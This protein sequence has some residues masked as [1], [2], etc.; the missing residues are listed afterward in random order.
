MGFF[1][2]ADLIQ[3][4]SASASSSFFD[5][6]D[7]ME[8]PKTAGFWERTG[9][10]LLNIPKEGSTRLGE[11]LIGMAGMALGDNAEVTRGVQRQFRDYMG[12]AELQVAAP[13][14]VAETTAQKAADLIF[15]DVAPTI[16]EAVAL[17]LGRGGSLAKIMAREAGRGAVIGAASADP[18][19]TAKSAAMWGAAGGIGAIPGQTAKRALLRI[20]GQA[21]VP[22]AAAAIDP[23]QEALSR[24]TLVNALVQGGFGAVT[25][26]TV[27]RGVRSLFKRKVEPRVVEAETEVLPPETQLRLQ[28]GPNAPMGWRRALPPQGVARSEDAIPMRYGMRDIPGDDGLTTAMRGEGDVFANVPRGLRLE[29]PEQFQARNAEQAL[30]SLRQPEPFTAPPEQLVQGPRLS[31]TARPENTTAPAQDARL[32]ST[33]QPLA[34]G[35]PMSAPRIA[36]GVAIETPTVGAEPTPISQATTEPKRLFRRSAAQTEGSQGEHAQPTDMRLAGIEQGAINP[37]ALQS[38]GGGIAGGFYGYSQGETD[39]ERARNAVLFA[40]AGAAG[41]IA[42]SKAPD[43]RRSLLRRS[44]AYHNDPSQQTLGNR[45]AAAITGWT[46]TGEEAPG[47]LSFQRGKGFVNTLSDELEAV[48]RRVTPAM[49]AAVQADPQLQAALQRFNASRGG[50]ADEIALRTAP[51]MPKEYAEMMITGNRV[52][53]A[54]QAEGARAEPPNSTKGHILTN[55]SGTY[56]TQSYGIFLDPKNWKKDPAAFNAVVNQT[57]RATGAP[58]EQVVREL[59]AYLADL[60][61][62]TDYAEAGSKTKISQHLYTQ[63]ENLTPEFKK[64]LGD[65]TD[66]AQKQMLT[67]QKLLKS[68]G[69][70]RTINELSSA[71][72]PNGMPLVMDTAAMNAA[73]RAGRD[74]GD[75]VR[76]GDSPSLGK[77]AGKYVPVNVAQQ[78]AR[79]NSI[80]ERFFSGVI[81]GGIR[82]A[83]SVSKAAMT[84]ANWAT[85]ARQWAQVPFFVLASKGNPLLIREAWSAMK[86]KS[87]PIW[88]ELRENDVIGA[89]F[90]HNE[91]ARHAHKIGT[92]EGLLGKAWGGIK[93]F[94]GLPDD[95]VRALAYVTAKKRY[96]G[97]VAKAVEHVNRFTMNYG[98]QSRLVNVA[99]EVPIVNPFISF[100]SEMMRVSKNLA[101]EAVNG[102]TI[103]DKAWAL[104]ALGGMWGAGVAVTAGTKAA[105]TPAER[106]EWDSIEKLMPSWQRIQEKAILGRNK[107]GGRDFV[108]LNALTPAGDLLGFANALAKGDWEAVFNDNPFVG[109]HKSPLVSAMIDTKLLTAGFTHDGQHHFTNKPIRTHGETFSRLTEAVM[110]P[111]LGYESPGGV[112]FGGFEGRKLS[113]LFHAGGQWEDPRS[114]RE[115][116]VEKAVKRN[117][118]GVNVQSVKRDSLLRNAAFERDQELRRINAEAKSALR[119]A[120]NTEQRRAIVKRKNE[121]RKEVIRIFKRK[122]G[123]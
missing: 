109:L 63:R 92:K 16:A 71:V 24:E 50:L 15:G 118:F 93:D 69:A 20:G 13:K 34:V 18:V 23:E 46:R 25:D 81:G 72:R 73:Q 44:A 108:G 88:R 85:H 58:R 84:V 53:R 111:L 120:D 57:M 104:A 11:S 70:F 41:P 19:E 37:V 64:L 75:Y 103:A 27:T 117:L 61:R 1:D 56:K 42:L 33:N 76:L 106:K 121:R 9:R 95:L 8:M 14:G 2:E 122:A 52:Q 97:N 12:G 123:S 78:I 80:E 21:A 39:E 32:S 30:A 38:L 47:L 35:E 87:N 77:L 119:T 102:A 26:P 43:A 4:P 45:I 110:P 6:Q 49:H 55:T 68:A 82:K 62:G 112:G 7:T 89:N 59:D 96:G 65:V 3:E 67:A 28:E 99:R 17:P 31:P 66:P 107:A 94:Y 98:A 5:P 79:Q 48:K 114:G 40:L 100:V 91:F 29:T 90:T 116:N 115:D 83:A 51:N 60:R 74:V 113:R 86:D 36:T 54:V 105:M 22:V 101:D 10:H